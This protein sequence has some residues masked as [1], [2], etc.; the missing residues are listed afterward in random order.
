MNNPVLNSIG[1]N[2]WV[3]LLRGIAA[4]IF[5]IVALFWPG[6]TAYA[7][8][9]TFGVYVLADGILAIYTAFQRKPTDDQWWT[10]LI[11]GAL[12]IILGLMALFSTEATA[13]ALLIWIAAWAIVVGVMRIIGAIRLRKIIDG[14]W[15]L[16][17]S[18]LLMIIWGVA[19]A[20]MPAAG[21]VSLTWVFGILS[22]LLG[23]ALIALAFRVKSLKTL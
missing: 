1:D 9:L 21:I 23:G 8:V 20:M 2:W 19:L 6:L 3:F 17:L 7:L 13:L 5:G 10:W 11:D 22:I 18:G 14:E 12:S 15:A 16:G 4:I